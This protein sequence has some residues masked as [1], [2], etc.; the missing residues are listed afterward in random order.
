ML[1]V[2]E[3][4]PEASSGQ[5]LVA[6]EYGLDLSE[7]ARDRLA[8]ATPEDTRIARREMLVTAGRPHREI[9]RLSRQRD[10]DLI[11]LGVH[12]RR[13]VDR[14]LP[15]TTVSHVLRAA[16]CP[17]LAVRPDAKQERTQAALATR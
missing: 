12:A 1:H 11:V 14:R 8:Q 10:V 5:P 17:V 6:P 15:G 4:F 16:P 9:L 13:A 3:W 7:D 2:M